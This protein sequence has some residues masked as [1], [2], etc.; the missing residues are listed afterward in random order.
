MYH[1]LGRHTFERNH[2][3][4]D[5]WYVKKRFDM[6]QKRIL[7]HI[8][9]IRLWHTNNQIIE[10]IYIANKSKYICETQIYIYI[11]IWLTVWYYENVLCNIVQFAD[12]ATIM[13]SQRMTLWKAAVPP[14][15]HCRSTDV[16]NISF[17]GSCYFM[18]RS[19]IWL[20]IYLADLMA[21]IATIRSLVR[22]ADPGT[23]IGSQRMTL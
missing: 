14:E 4:N 8:I 20:V 17:G 12:S 21:L 5:Y 19:S 23:I 22:F 1:T 18:E 9:A 6:I 3:L 11:Y 15:T 7:I 13:C 10:S 2:L 16:T